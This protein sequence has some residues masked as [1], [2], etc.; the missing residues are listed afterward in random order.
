MENKTQRTIKGLR[1]DLNLTQKEMA[2]ALGIPICNYQRYEKLEVPVPL[3]VMIKIA[4][5]VGIVDI[6]EIKFE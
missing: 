3:K 2:D 6:R 1:S 5:M 4:D